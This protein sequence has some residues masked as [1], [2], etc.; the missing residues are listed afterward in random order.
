MST[1]R[2][3]QAQTHVAN[4]AFLRSPI[5]W[6]T[7]TGFARRR[8]TSVMMNTFRQEGLCCKVNVS[9]T[10]TKTWRGSQVWAHAVGAVQSVEPFWVPAQPKLAPLQAAI[11]STELL[12]AHYYPSSWLNLY[13]THFV[14]L[15]GQL[16]AL[17]QGSFHSSRTTSCSHQW[18]QCHYEQLRS[19]W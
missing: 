1:S 15:H 5:R 8:R 10:F 4:H 7:C 17:D 3:P 16:H 11:S 9:A 19:D 2:L 12:E 14:G 18:P 6:K 13:S